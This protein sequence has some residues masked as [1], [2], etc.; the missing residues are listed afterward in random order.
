MKAI[1]RIEEKVDKI[2]KVQ[3]L[4]DKIGEQEPEVEPEETVKILDEN[5]KIR[6]ELLPDLCKTNDITSRQYVKL[7]KA[8]GTYQITSGTITKDGK[9]P[10]LV[11]KDTDTFTVQLLQTDKT[12]PEIS[13][14]SQD[15]ETKYFNIDYQV[16]D[17]WTPFLNDGD[18]T[19]YYYNYATIDVAK[20]IIPEELHD[21]DLQITFGLFYETISTLTHT[22]GLKIKGNL[23]VSDNIIFNN[24]NL[25]DKLNENYLELSNKINENKSTLT[26][27][28]D[29][30]H[31]HTIN[32]VT[33]LESELNEMKNATTK[34]TESINKLNVQIVNP[35]SPN[36][37]W[38]FDETPNVEY[39]V[40][41]ETITIN[42]I[43]Y[44]Q[45]TY[46]IIDNTHMV[47]TIYH[48]DNGSDLI[49]RIR[50]AS[51][52]IVTIPFNNST[53]R[54]QADS[55]SY[56]FK[57]EQE[58]DLNTLKE[59]QNY[60]SSSKLTIYYYYSRK[61]LLTDITEIKYTNYV[62]NEKSIL[63]KSA[64]LDYLY[65]VGTIYV[66]TIDNINLTGRFGGTWVS[67]TALATGA[68][69]W[70]RTA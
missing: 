6:T 62:I 38:Q 56:Y 36:Y 60:N 69:A 19:V 5:N 16:D 44:K 63:I 34:N 35:D 51:T 15:G 55:G 9:K 24:T 26:T 7:D 12:L 14:R 50:Y 57:F 67:I 70:K 10:S 46:K 3:E 68:Y 27:K 59:L 43:I 4:A 40:G 25:T 47:F 45:A 31:T 49:F 11:I 2:I 39:Q 32:D 23:T 21:A 41:T 54:V 30:K 28:A 18:K 1:D 48:P 58:I 52:D 66:G 42:E 20:I 61:G 64:I 22:D 17:E 33:D 8:I 13:I 65:P 29:K 37:Y 53:E